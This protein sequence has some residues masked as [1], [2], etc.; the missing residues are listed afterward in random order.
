MGGLISEEHFESWQCLAKIVEYLYGQGRNGWT[1][2]STA[3][4]HKAVL[5]YNILIEESQ[6]LTSCHIVNHNLTHIRE[7]VLNFGSPD[8]FWRYNYE[9]A[10]GQYVAISTNH[11]NIE[12][13]FTWAELRREILKELALKK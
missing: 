9:C 5:R 10:V 12:I 1:V 4:F 3:V 13:T 11:K 8:S 7:D 2:D 6:G